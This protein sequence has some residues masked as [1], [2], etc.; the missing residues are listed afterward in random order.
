V[1][2]RLLS[3]WTAVQLAL[4]LLA[5]GVAVTLL[6]AA[7]PAASA[8][9]PVLRGSA[10]SVGSALPEVKS[11]RPGAPPRQVGARYD[12]D[13]AMPR[14][15]EDI[16]SYTL[17]VR[18]DPGK[19]TLTAKGTIRW[20]N[21][22]SK[23][24]HEL[25]LHLY[26][27]AF[28]NDRTLFLRSPFGAGRSGQKAHEWGYIDVHKLVARELGNVDLWKHA[29]RHSPDDPDDQTDIRVPLPKPVEPGQTLTLDT[30]W[31]ARLPEI[32]ERTGYS[33]SF[34]FVGQWFPKLARRDPDGTWVHFEFHP[35]SE[36]YADYGRYDVTI[37]VPESMRVGATGPR[38]S[39]HVSGGRR[40]VR[41]VIDDVH[42]FAW[43]AW[44]KFKEKHERID[45]VNVRVLY[46]PGQDDNARREL[47]AVRFTLP[48]YSRLYGRY[49]YPVLTLVHPPEYAR[50]SGG[51]EYP[52]LIS[53]GGPWYA[54]ALGVRIVEDV[55]IHELGHQWF[56]GLVA[57]DEHAWPF[58]DEGLNT[59]AEGTAMRAHYGDG[60]LVDALG[61]QVSDRAFRRAA[62]SAYGH[63]QLV[64]LPAPRFA[65]FREMGAIVY[66]RTGTIMHTVAN[67]YGEDRVQRALGRYARRYRFQHP[68]PQH[69]LGVMREVLGE[70]AADNLEDALFHRG[71][72]DYVVRDLQ[73]ARVRP[74]GGIFDRASG[75]ETVPREATGSASEWV[76]RVLVF[77]HG[78]LRFPVDVELVS[79]DGRRTRRH[80]NGRGTWT[81]IEYRG[82]SPLVGAVVDPDQRIALDDNLLNNAI[83]SSPGGAP[84]SL[85][86][87]LYAA[88]LLLGA[89]GP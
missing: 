31:T 38:V 23:P 66:A 33:G 78:S 56:Y 65:D 48:F 60:S 29:A 47:D 14:H 10:D 63:D 25:W 1:R 86:R 20:K 82:P 58:L 73:T 28:K 61:L 71:W 39:S 16:A 37:D 85:E 88:E 36:F 8:L 80:W 42:D 41:H 51:M 18:L 57:T 13:A 68:G 40:V 69:F 64:A 59:F 4:G 46:P 84:R 55:T 54:G 12:H 27:N 11:L 3:P 34:Y 72:V 67:V 79:R 81:S 89:L 43:S 24:A 62:S 19:H 30:A 22:S 70:D 87:G 7:Q 83:S 52:T 21:A 45:G 50:N 77:R 53:T 32:V 6:A 76:G 5:G 2:R 75:R 15:A 74:P 17:R 26:L 49:P 44:D 35:Q 9:V